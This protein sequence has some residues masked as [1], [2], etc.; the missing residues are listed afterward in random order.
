[1]SPTRIIPFWQR[2]PAF[3]LYPLKGAALVTLIALTLG[4][5]FSAIFPFGGGATL[6]LN[7]MLLCGA[8]AMAVQILRETAQGRMD[9]PEGI[10]E[11]GAG[12]SQIVLQFCFVLMMVLGFAFGPGIGIAIAILLA[13]AMPAATMS[14]AIDENFWHALNPGTWF[15]IAGR[16]GWPYFAMVMIS[17]VIL[18]SQGNAQAVLATVMGPIMAPVTGFFIS[19][20]ALF[21]YFN[22]LGYVIYQYHEELGYEVE[23]PLAR[24]NRNADPDQDVLDE[25]AQ[26]VLDGD[27]AGAEQRLAQQLRAR[28]GTP[29]VHAQYRKLL[30]M[31]GD[32]AAASG[33][34]R[35]YLSV[36]LA[37]DNHKG[38][39]E[40][41]RDCVQMD[42][43]FRLTQP[44][45]VA[46]LA[47][48]AADL[49]PRVAVQLLADFAERF[50]THADVAANALLEAKLRAEKL[51]DDAGARTRLAAVRAQLA[52]DPLAGEIDAYL[53]FLDKLAAPVARA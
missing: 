34:G 12:K 23:A 20:W 18:V 13:F 44:D 21:M 8:Y 17:A 7:F 50:P 25:V 24:P 48:R 19:T 39:I 35:E 28:G 41:L 4:S 5:A 26:M 16:L 14:L 29:A 1:M 49:H 43:E 11:G 33:H 22:L 10:V 46:P 47:R 42:P 51:G 53:G 30:R 27:T 52:Y 6:I 2:L 36:L 45:Q 15:A 38:A 40:L 31:R 37:Q 3:A 32:I 9:S